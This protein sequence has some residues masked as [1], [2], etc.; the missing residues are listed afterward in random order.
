VAD[1]VSRGIRYYYYLPEESELR[2]RTF[3]A[4]L[5][6]RLSMPSSEI[7]KSLCF[8]IRRGVY[9][10]PL[11]TVLHISPEGSIEGYVGLVSGDLVQ[12]YQRAD[13]LLSWRLYQAFLM[14]F[15]LSLNPETQ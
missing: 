8:Y 2:Y 7:D 9:E 3:I 4:N 13:T 6:E 10:F 11:N 14:A 15:S 5:S 12:Y 1:N